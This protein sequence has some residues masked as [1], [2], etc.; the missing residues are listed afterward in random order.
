MHGLSAFSSIFGISSAARARSQR[1]KSFLPNGG[2]VPIQVPRKPAGLGGVRS[3]CLLVIAQTMLLRCVGATEPL[4]R[5][6]QAGF[7]PNEFQQ[8]VLLHA[9]CSGRWI[10]RLNF[11]LHI[12]QTLDL[13]NEHALDSSSCLPGN[14]RIGSELINCIRNI[15]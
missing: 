2:E 13:L 1:I 12:M 9:L 7:I 14:T 15:P 6:C 8:I 5:S 10:L 4:T 3:V 11:R